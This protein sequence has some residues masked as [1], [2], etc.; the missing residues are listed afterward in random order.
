MT[1]PSSEFLPHFEP[2]APWPPTGP[3]YEGPPEGRGSSGRRGG[4]TGHAWGQWRV[5]HVHSPY[6]YG[7]PQQV[8]LPPFPLCMSDSQSSSRATSFSARSSS[9][10]SSSDGPQP[11][12]GGAGAAGTPEGPSAE[13]QLGSPLCPRPLVVPCGG[14]SPLPTAQSLSPQKLSDLLSAPVPEAGV[15]MPLPETAFPTDF[16]DTRPA[17][18]VRRAADMSPLL[19]NLQRDSFSTASPGSSGGSTP[20]SRPEQ[21]WRGSPQGP[22]APSHTL[23]T[24]RQAPCRAACPAPPLPGPGH[25]PGMAWPTSAAAV[26][27]GLNPPPPP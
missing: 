20:T 21:I 11:L 15:L 6:T 10:S 18:V 27:V 19:R 9:A 24:T 16:S 13:P 12:L 7:G 3:Y 23:P 14:P 17:I 2:P 26:P 1:G 8:V 5:A 4:S 22:P 25:A